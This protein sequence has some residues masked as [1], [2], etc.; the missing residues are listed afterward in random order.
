[1][2]RM[3]RRRARGTRQGGFTLIEVMIALSMLAAGLLTVAAA[4][5]YAMRGGTTGRHTSDAATVAHSQLE[6]LQR[7]SFEDDDLDA[8]G[9]VWIPDGGLAVPR[10]VQATPVDAV[11]MTYTMQ[12]R[13]S[14]VDPNLKAV[15]VR[16]IWDEPQRPGRSLTLSTQLHNDP[17]TGG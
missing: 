16:V 13:I 10:T 11:E 17:Q 2:D 7:M 1:M 9:G 12:W 15:D 6:N 8:T 4:Q 5:L 14:D 3:N